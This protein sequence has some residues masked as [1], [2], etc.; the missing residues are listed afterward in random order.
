MHS[1]PYY[2]QVVP[3]LLSHVFELFMHKSHRKE[4]M[5]VSFTYSFVDGID[6]NVFIKYFQY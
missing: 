4:D 3:N 2:I 6:F 1:N 5:Y